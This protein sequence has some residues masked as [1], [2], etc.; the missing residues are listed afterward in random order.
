MKVV[1]IVLFNSKVHPTFEHLAEFIFKDAG[2]LNKK[3]E[4]YRKRKDV[5]PQLQASRAASFQ[6]ITRESEKSEKK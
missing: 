2:D 1:A 3:I 5:P 4:N 6:I